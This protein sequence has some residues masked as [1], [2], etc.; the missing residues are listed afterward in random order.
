[1]VTIDKNELRVAIVVLTATAYFTIFYNIFQDGLKSFIQNHILLYT[2]A[3]IIALGIGISALKILSTQQK[4]P[5]E[6]NMSF[7]DS[8]KDKNENPLDNKPN[9][10]QKMDS[11]VN[12]NSHGNKKIRTLDVMIV[13]V[14]IVCGVSAVFFQ[15][16]Q[17]PITYSSSEAILDPQNRSWGVTSYNF[18][19]TVLSAQN[20]IQVSAIIQLDAN[21]VKNVTNNTIPDR[22]FIYFQQ[23]SPEHPIYDHD[24]M[25][26]SYMMLKLANPNEL[27]Y[28]NSTIIVY[29]S[30]G[31]KCMIVTKQELASAQNCPLNIHPTI[32][33]SSAD[34]KFQ[35]DANRN[36]FSV[37]FI[38]LAF[39]I[40]LLRDFIISMAHNLSRLNENKYK[41]PK[42]PT[43]KDNPQNKKIKDKNLK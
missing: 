32:H 20:P 3:G 37:T 22:M 19:S 42:E 5:N 10:K 21:Y 7:Q 31:D 41:K 43:S 33:I 34:S 8:S 14:I 11:S 29:Q 12:D 9:S 38:S 2:I 24:R 26:S 13:V 35:L 36:I 1:M 25:L 6:Q 16:Y 27:L 39:T 17:P 4:K 23:A 30:E 28:K 15:F 18:T 40:I